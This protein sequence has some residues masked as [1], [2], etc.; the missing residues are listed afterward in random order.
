ME[1]FILS[2]LTGHGKDN[3][4]TRSSQHGFMKGRSCLTHLI[5]FYNQVTNVVDEG[6]AVDVIYL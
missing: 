5:S 2:V 1:R 6:K 4:G 3:Q